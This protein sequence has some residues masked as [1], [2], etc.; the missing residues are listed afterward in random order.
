MIKVAH[1]GGSIVQATPE[2]ASVAELAAVVGAPVGLVLDQAIAAAHSA[3]LVPGSPVPG[4][5]Q[6]AEPTRSMG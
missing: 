4:D 6:A 3:G 5:A 1:R 2:F